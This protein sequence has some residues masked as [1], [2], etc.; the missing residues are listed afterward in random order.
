MKLFKK[1]AMCAMCLA[2]ALPVLAGCGGGSALSAYDKEG[3]RTVKILVHVAAS[4]EEGIAYKKRVDAFNEYYRDQKI[5]ASIEFKARS[6]GA[7]GYETELTNLMNGGRMPDIITFDAPNAW[8]YAGTYL[9]PMDEYVSQATVNDIPEVSRNY[10]AD[11]K[12]YG[13]PIQESSAGIYYNKDIMRR[14]GVLDEIQNYTVQNPWTFEQ[15]KSVCQRIKDS[16][17]LASGGYPVDM[18]LYATED[19][20]ATYLLYPFVMATGGKMLSDDGK[21]AKG[22]LNSEQSVKGFRFLKDIESAGYTSYGIDKDG[23]FTGKHAMYLSSGWTIPDIKNKYRETFPNEE[24]WGILP[25][26]KDVA[27]VSPTASWSFG[28]A[29]IDRGDKES[30]IKLLEWM[31]TPA[32]SAAITTATGMIPARTS[33]VTDNPYAA[34]SAEKVLYDQLVTT[35]KKRPDT[36]AYSTFSSAFANVIIGLKNSDDVQNVVKSQTDALQADLDLFF[37]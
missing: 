23:F 6:S 36:A 8:N 10:G 22:Y 35:G 5:K 7:T 25:Y 37:S 24:S 21:T 14:A 34:G 29:N 33:V 12:L 30:V 13:L 3:N 32:S 26:P 20:T 31:V 9:A 18:R 11:G 4:S 15:F 28:M 19:E 2:L 16:G 1:I 27:A 17:V